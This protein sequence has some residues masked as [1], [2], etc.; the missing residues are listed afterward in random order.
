[1]T[2]NE[3]KPITVTELASIDAKR[4]SFKSSAANV[5]EGIVTFKMVTKNRKKEISLVAVGYQKRDGSTAEYPA[6]ETESGEAIALSAFRGKD[7]VTTLD[8]KVLN[9]PNL[10]EFD[11]NY[12]NTYNALVEIINKGGNIRL[13]RVVGRRNGYKGRYEIFTVEY[14]Q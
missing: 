13:T 7:P 14:P 9:C 12:E 1:M 5:A 6:V 8:G 3:R 4:K 2:T 10:V 11:E